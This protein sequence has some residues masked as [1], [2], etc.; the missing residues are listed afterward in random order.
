MF[1]IQDE[2]FSHENGVV[3]FSLVV[4]GGFRNGAAW[5]GYPCRSSVLATTRH[6]ID[7][8]VNAVKISNACKAKEGARVATIVSYYDIPELGEKCICQTKGR[9]RCFL[10]LH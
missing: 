8:L 5:V 6:Q 1:A 4:F 2:R 10:F 3:I 9:I 7:I